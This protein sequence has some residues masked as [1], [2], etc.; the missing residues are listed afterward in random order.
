MIENRLSELLD[1]AIIQKMA[2]AQYEAAG[3]PIGII[4]AIDGSRNPG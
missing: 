3:M 1:L 4:D 2:H